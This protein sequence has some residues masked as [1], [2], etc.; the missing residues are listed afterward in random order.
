MAST[1]IPDHLKPFEPSESKAAIRDLER[2]LENLIFK[3]E[4][5]ER[6]V[7]LLGSSMLTLLSKE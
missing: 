2:N 6:K 5:L 1:T 3:M 7:E 4:E